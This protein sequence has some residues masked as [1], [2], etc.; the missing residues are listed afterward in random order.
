M[1]ALADEE[2]YPEEGMALLRDIREMIQNLNSRWSVFLA[3]SEISRLNQAAGDKAVEISDDTRTILRDS[4][5]YAELTDGIFDIT[6]R[7]LSK[8]WNIGKRGT[9]IPSQDEISRVIPL[10]GYQDI[11]LKKDTAFLKKKGEAADLGGIAKGFAADLAADYLNKNHV[12]EYTVNFGGTVVTKG[13]E[14]KIG[15]RNPFAGLLASNRTAGYVTVKDECV[16]TSGTYE[17]YFIKD[18]VRYHHILDPKTGQPAH[19]NLASVTLLG[20][21]AEELDVLCTTVILLGAKEGAA[22]A[23]DRHVRG[24]FISEEG[25]TFTTG[26]DVDYHI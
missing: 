4:I 3:D 8:L 14:K 22:L 21:N 1:P 2:R 5:R 26:K 25:K 10:I 11:V 19:T 24:I 17:R 23:K 12:K 7:P 16:V 6:T 13:E 15:I 9:Y 18:G 20:K